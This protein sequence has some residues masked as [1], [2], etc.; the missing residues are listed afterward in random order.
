[1]VALEVVLD[2][3]IA[4][5]FSFLAIYSGRLANKVGVFK[6]ANAW[7]MFSVSAL[8][9]ALHHL[10]DLFRM[11]GPI[12]E[13]L[14]ML[15]S[16]LWTLSNTIYLVSAVCFMLATRFLLEAFLKPVEK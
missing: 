15:Q 2:V 9:M 10:I 11:F 4:A 12:E 16:P 1:M 6:I 13:R 8:I 14:F 7:I 5:E 3:V